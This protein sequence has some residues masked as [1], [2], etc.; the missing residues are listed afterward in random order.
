M[1]SSSQARR[2]RAVGADGERI[3]GRKCVEPLYRIEAHARLQPM[4]EAPLEQCHVLAPGRSTR[5]EW[6]RFLKP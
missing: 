1:P 5:I 6:S 4:H 3:A 2:E